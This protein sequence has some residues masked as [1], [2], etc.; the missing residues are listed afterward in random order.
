MYI[1][2]NK[3]D[4]DIESCICLNSSV[5]AEG[6]SL[7]LGSRSSWL[8][9]SGDN[10]IWSRYQLHSEGDDKQRAPVQISVW[11]MKWYMGSCNDSGAPCVGFSRP[12]PI[13]PICLEVATD[14]RIFI[15]YSSCVKKMKK[16]KKKEKRQ[17]RLHC[18]EQRGQG[19]PPRWDTPRCPKGGLCPAWGK[20]AK[21]CTAWPGAP[22]AL[23]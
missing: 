2:Q 5:S 21:P 16:E 13:W 23:P 15:Y 10:G 14:F 6:K 7:L 12:K 9:R 17:W 19:Q 3:L 20:P 18:W 11:L 4:R 1:L 22:W 8:P